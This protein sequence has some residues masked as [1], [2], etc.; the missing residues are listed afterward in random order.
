MKPI[1]R[2]GSLFIKINYTDE[3]VILGWFGFAAKASASEPFKNNSESFALC[4]KKQL[5]SL[6]EG[7]LVVLRYSMYCTANDFEA[8][9][10]YHIRSVLILWRWYIDR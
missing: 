1:I 6:F 7:S 5:T 3:I 4:M 10:R 9:H 8:A 2:L